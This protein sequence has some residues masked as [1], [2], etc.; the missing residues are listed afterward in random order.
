MLFHVYSCS[1]HEN[2][3]MAPPCKNTQIVSLPE[4]ELFCM[5]ADKYYQI[6]GKQWTERG[7]N[8]S[9]TEEGYIT[10]EFGLEQVYGIEINSI[11]ELMALKNEVQAD[12]VLTISYLDYKT[13]AIEILR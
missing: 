12:L 8:H 13:P 6:Y 5:S 10:R 2:T 7:T 4:V 3:N 1:L 11:D 9:I